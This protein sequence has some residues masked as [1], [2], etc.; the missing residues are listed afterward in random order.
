MLTS[1]TRSP[2]TFKF[3]GDFS[4]LKKKIKPRSHRNLMFKVRDFWEKP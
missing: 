3:Q 2:R 4:N 1:K